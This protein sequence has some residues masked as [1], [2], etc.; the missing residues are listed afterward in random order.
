MKFAKGFVALVILTSLLATTVRAQNSFSA[1]DFAQWENL[2]KG[3]TV[4]DGQGVSPDELDDWGGPDYWGY[5][6]RD[7]NEL[8]GPTYAWVDV[9]GVGEQ[10]TITDTDDGTQLINLLFPFWFYGDYYNQVNISSNGNIHFGASDSDWSNSF[11]PSTDGP[12]AMIAP[13]WDDIAVHYAN[14]GDIY[15]YSTADSFIVQ[16]ENVRRHVLAGTDSTSRYTF[17]VIIYPDSRIKFQY[18]SM[19]GTLNSATIGIENMA[20]TGGLLILYN[21]GYVENNLAIEIY[22]RPLPFTLGTPADGFVSGST[23]LDLTWNPSLNPDPTE[24]LTYN[25]FA[26]TDPTDMGV[27][28]ATGIA[29]TF[30]NFTGLD[31]ATYYWTIL[32]ND[33]ESPGTQADDT[34]SFHITVPEPPSAFNLLTPTDGNTEGSTTPTLTWSASVDP[35]AGDVVTYNIIYSIGDAT[36]ADPDSIT[37]INATSYTFPDGTLQDDITVYWYVRAVDTNT[38]GTLS[39]RNP[40][41]NFAYRFEIYETEAPAAFN[42]SGPA[43]RVTVFD[44]DTTLS[45]QS[46]TEPDP[47]DALTGYMLWVATNEAFTQNLDSVAFTPL[48]TTYTMGGLV[49]NTTYWWKVRA[50]DGNTNGT[51]SDQTLSFHYYEPTSPAA[52]TPSSPANHSNHTTSDV[53][54]EWNSSSDTNPAN[55]L[56]IHGPDTFGYFWLDNNQPGGPNYA[57]VD[58]SGTG[59]PS[60]AA[61]GAE[62]Q[63]VVAIPFNFPFYGVEYADITID[64]NGYLSFGGASDFS[65]SGIPGIDGPQGMIAA[66]WDDLQPEAIGNIYYQSMGTWFVVQYDGVQRFAD[67][68]S[69]ET[70]QIILFDDGRIR[71]QYEDVSGTLNSCTVGIENPDEN[72]GLEVTFN[73]N[74][75]DDGLALEFYPYAVTYE[76]EWATVASFAGSTIEETVDAT[77]YNITGCPDN[78]TMYWRAHATNIYNQSTTIT[79]NTGWDFTTS[80]PDPP[81]GFNLTSPADGFV[82]ATTDII[83]QWEEATDPDIGDVITYEVYITEIDGV[84]G[85][86]VAT[87]LA[88]NQYSFTGSFGTQ[89]WWRIRAIDNGGLGTYSD[90]TWS[91]EIVTPTP[92][93]AFNVSS[94]AI[95][96]EFANLTPTVVWRQTTDNDPGDAVNYNVIWSLNDATF[97][98]PDSVTGLS[99][100]TYTF[101]AGDLADD[102]TV[103]WYVRATD[104]NTNGRNS[105]QNPNNNNTWSFTTN[106]PDVPN[107]FGLVSPANNGTPNTAAVTLQWQAATDPD[108]GDNITYEVYVATTPGGFGGPTAAGLNTTQYVFNGTDNQQYYWKV[109]A[110]DT[111]SAGTWSTET[112]TFTIVEPD[113]PNAFDLTGPANGSTLQTTT[114]TLTWDAATDPDAGDVIT[115][116]LV[117]SVG[118]ATFSDPDSVTG[119]TNATYTFGAGTLSDDITLY[120]YVRA[121]DTNTNGTLSSQNPNNGNTWSFSIAVDEAPSAFNLLTPADGTTSLNTTVSLTWQASSDPDPGDNVTYDVYVSENQATVQN[122]AS[123]VATGLNVTNLDYAGVDNHVYYWQIQAI[124]TDGNS[125]WSSQQWDFSI[126]VPDPPDAFNLTGPLDNATVTSA[127]P[128]LTWETTTDPDIGDNVTYNVIWAVNDPTFADPDSAV[129]LATATYTFSAGIL[130]DDQPVYWYVRAVDTNTNGRL[131][132]QNPND[133]TT[134]HFDMNVPE[135]PAV[136]DLVSPADGVYIEGLT[137]NLEWDATTDPDPGDIINYEVYVS[138]DQATVQNIANRVAQSLSVVTYAFNGAEDQTYYWTIRAVDTGNN[139]TWASTTRSF[140]FGVSETPDAFSLMAPTDGETVTTTTPILSWQTATDPDPGDVVTY[141]VIWSRNDATFS[142]PDSATGIATANYTFS[143]GSINDGDQVYWYVRAVD[144][145]TNGRL[146]TQNPNDGTTWSFD[147]AIAEAPVAFDLTAPANGITLAATT[148]DLEWNASSDPD[149]GDVITYDVYLSTDPGTLMNPGSRIAQGVSNTFYTFNGT[150]DQTYYWRIKAIDSNSPGTWSNQA[151]SF[152]F[153]I[154]EQPTAFNLLTP[155]NMAA[156]NTLTPTLTWQQSTDPDPGDAVSYTL[157]YSI[158]DAS[159]AAPTTIT[160]LTNETWSFPAGILVDEDVVHWY[161]HAV[162]NNTAGTLSTPNPVDGTARQ[163]EITI[164]DAPSSFSLLGPANGSTTTST[165]VVF[166]WQESTDPDAGDVVTYD[167]YVSQDLLTLQDVGNRVAQGLS[168]E[169]YTFNGQDDNSYFWQ[170]KAV[171]TNSPGTW[172]T[173]QWDFSISNP[174]QPTAFDLQTPSDGITVNTTTPTLTWDV[175]TD[176]DAGDNVTY[177]VIWSVDD[178]TFSSPDSV[179]GLTATSYTFSAGNLPDNSTVHWYVRAIDTNTNGRL[180]TRNPRDNTAYSF[181]ILVPEQPSSF[182]LLSPADGSLSPSTSVTLNWEASVDPDPG[183]AVTYEVYISSNQATVTDPASRVAQNVVST[184]YTYNGT[185]NSQYFWTIKA[186]DMNTTGRWATQTWDFSVGVADPPSEFAL[187]GPADG[188]TILDTTEV[189]F[190]WEQATDPDA[191][192][193]VTYRLYYSIGDI[194]FTNPTV[195]SGI[196]DTTYTLAPGILEDGHQ[197]YWYVRAYDTNS[198]TYTASTPAPSNGIPWK[199]DI[200]ITDAPEPF[201]LVSPINNSTTGNHI[202]TLTW[203]DTEDPDG[204]HTPTFDVYLASDTTGGLRIPANRIVNGWSD[205]TYTFI[206]DDDSTYYWT[207]YATDNNTV[208]T[209]ANQAW[210]FTIGEAESPTAFDLISPTNGATMGTT[211]PTLTWRRSTDPDPGD[212]VTYRLYWSVNDPTFASPAFVSGLTD[213][214]YTFPGGVLNDDVTYYWYVLA[215]DGNTA[216]TPSNQSPQNGNPYRFDVYVNDTPAAFSLLSPVNNYISP[217]T[218]VTLTW[219]ASSESDPG[220]NLTY[221]VYLSTNLADLGQPFTRVA[222]GLTNTTHT[223]TLTDD[224]TYYWQVKA[225]DTN[226]AGTISNETWQFSIGVPDAPSA[227]A[228]VSPAAGVVLT[229]TTPTLT[230]ER[231]TDPDPGDALTYTVYW[232][233]S[234]PSFTTPAFTAGLTDTSYTFPAGI[235]NDHETVYWYVK[236][237]DTN[238]A[239]TRSTP[240]PID[241]TARSFEIYIIDSPSAFNL[242][243]PDQADTVTSLDAQLSWEESVDPDV[244]DIVTYNVYVSFDLG[245]LGNPA[246]LIASGLDTTGY[247]FHGVED[248]LYYWTVKAVDTNSPGTWADEVRSFRIAIPERP[249]PFNLGSPA[250]NIILQTMTPTLTWHP[251]TDADPGDVVTYTVLYT[252]GDPLFIS[253]VEITG[254][255]DTSYTFAAGMLSD[256]NTV[257]WYVKAV[258]LNSEGRRS[259]QN[260]IDNTA[261]RF[262]LVVP[263]PPAAFTLLSPS[264]GTVATT[265]NVTLTW[266]STTDPDP[267]DVVTY[268]LYVSTLRN[269]LG[270]PVISGYAGTSYVYSGDDDST[271]YWAVVATDGNTAGTWS[272][273]TLSFSYSI[274]DQPAAFQLLTPSNNGVVADTLPTLTWQ[275]AIDPDPGD[276]VTYTLQYDFNADFST[277]TEVAGL[278]TTSYTLPTPLYD[279]AT[280]FWRVRAVD[281]NTAGTWAGPP[282]YFQFDVFVQDVPNPFN[283]VS[284]ANNGLSNP[285]GSVTLVWENNGDPDLGHEVVY[286]VYV[287]SQPDM[288]DAVSFGPYP[289]GTF[290]TLNQFWMQDDSTYYWRVWAQDEV[291]AD[292]RWSNEI[293]A[294]TMHEPELPYAFDLLTPANGD[295]SFDGSPTFTWENNGDPDPNQL[296]TYTLHLGQDAAFNNR[297]VYGPYDEDVF[298]TISEPWMVDGGRYWWKVY[299]H[300]AEGDSVQSAQTWSF[301]IYIPEPPSAFNRVY[302]P[303]DGQVEDLDPTL[304]WQRATD[305][306]PGDQITYTLEWSFNSDFSNLT[307]VTG[308]ADTFYTYPVGQLFDDARVY[309]RVRAV[310]RNSGTG[311]W[312]GPTASWSFTVY[313]HEQP[314]AFSLLTPADG[315][316]LDPS[317]SVIL[318]WENN[319][320]PDPNQGVSYELQVAENS[321]FT[322]SALYGPFNEGEFPTL[323]QLVLDDDTQYW[324]R[325]VAT[326][327]WTGGHVWSTET[328]T[329]FI[330]SPEVPLPFDLVSPDSGVTVPNLGPTLIWEATTD[331]DPGESVTYTLQYAFNAGF[332]PSTSIADLTDPVYTFTEAELLNSME[333]ML[334]DEELDE[335]LPDDVTVYWRVRA[336]DDSGRS[337]LSGPSAYWTFYVFV[338]DPPNAFSLISPANDD[339]NT[340]GSVTFRWENQ[341]DPDPGQNVTYTLHL[342]ENPWFSSPDVYGPYT[343]NDFPTFTPPILE[344]DMRYWWKVYAHDEVSGDSIVSNQAWSFWV[345]IPEPPGAFDR[346]SP[347]HL[348]EVNTLG[349]TLMWE[350]APE[351][352]SS[353]SVSYTMEWAFLPDF[354]GSDSVTSLVDTFYTFENTTLMNAYREQFG[355]DDNDLD[356]LLPDNVTVFWRVRAVDTNT[357]G[358]WAGPTPFW[359]FDIYW[360]QMPYPFAL[361]SPVLGDT[362]FDGSVTFEWENNGDPDPGQSVIYSIHVCDDITFDSDI[363]YLGTYAEGETPTVTPAWLEDDKQ[364]WWR[365]FA[366]DEVLGDSLASTDTSTFRTYFPELPAAFDLVSPEDSSTVNTLGP[367]LVWHASSDPDPDDTLTYRV[368]WGLTPQLPGS[369]VITGITDTTYTFTEEEISA[370]IREEYGS[371][372]EGELDELLPDDVTIYWRVHATDR[373]TAGTLSGPAEYWQFDV[374]VSESP[375]AFSLLS[376]LDM[377]TVWVDTVQLTWEASFDPDPDNE[378]AYDLL[379]KTDLDTAFAVIAT[380]LTDTTCILDS[381]QD[382]RIYQWTVYAQDSNTPGI[383]ANDTL[384]FSTY[385]PEPPADFSLLQP[386]D[387]VEIHTSVVNLR[388]EE[389]PDPDP[390]N[391]VTYD[392]Y[393]EIDGGH[394]GLIAS[395]LDTNSF[396]WTLPADDAEITWRVYARDTNTQ[397]TWSSNTFTMFINKHEPPLPFSLLSPDSSERLETHSPTVVWES[398]IDPDPYDWVTYTLVWSVNDP[399]FLLP[400]S[401]ANLDDTTFTFTSTMLNTGNNGSQSNT[402]ITDLDQV[403]FRAGNTAGSGKKQY[404]GLASTGSSTRSQT[405]STSLSGFGSST[406]QQTGSLTNELDSFVDDVTVYWYVRAVDQNS[407]GRLSNQN[408]VDNTLINFVID[409]PEPPEPFN[410]L[411]PSHNREIN[412]ESVVFRW[413]QT[414]DPDPNDPVTYEIY[415]SEDPDSMGNP[416]ASGLRS[417]NYTWFGGEDDVRY[418]W[419]VRAVDSNSEGRM[420]SQTWRFFMRLPNPPLTFNLAAP[421][422]GA[423]LYELTPTITWFATT[424][425]DPGDDITYTLYFADNPDFYDADSIYALS[426]TSVTIPDDFPFFERLLENNDGGQL[427]GVSPVEEIVSLQPRK[428]SAK[429]SSAK[430]KQQPSL[431][432]VA[433][434]QETGTVKVAS[435][436]GELNEG[437]ASATVYWR[438]KAYDSNSD[439]TWCTPEEGWTFDLFILQPPEPFD[440]ISPP[441]GM[442]STTDEITFEWGAGHDES[443]ADSIT[444]ILEL[445]TSS[446][447]VN[448]QRYTVGSA[449]S[450]T[451]TDLDDD[452]SYWWRVKARD[453]INR[454]SRSNQVWTVATSFPNPPTSFALLEPADSAI[455]P[456]TIPHE[457]RFAWQQSVDPDPEEAELLR[458]SITLDLYL[459]GAIDTSVTFREL[460]EHAQ[461]IDIVD[462]LGLTSWTGHLEINWYV[463]AISGGD[464]VRSFNGWT[465][466]L[467][468]PQ[469]ES[470]WGDNEIPTEYTV[471]ATYPNPFNARLMIVVALPNAGRVSFDIYNTLGQK[472]TSIPEREYRQGYHQISWE[473]TN[474]AAGM[475]FLR[476]NAPHGGGKVRRI[477][478]AP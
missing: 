39:T 451:V 187:I 267:G 18:A 217:S 465:V 67:A 102:A 191:G 260:P 411:L 220:D 1:S 47:D 296:V 213:T 22:G 106:V 115:Y 107:P 86:P 460:E 245:T 164:V 129:G 29:D 396:D 353:D 266:E 388:W 221:S 183:D 456:W 366:H 473:A 236:A 346:L 194:N 23:T 84:W 62:Q 226:T 180:S 278:T 291:L 331:P 297:S 79:P 208:G 274:P 431:S 438:V 445:S 254:L 443:N 72:D 299:A 364:Y 405:Y 227:F 172:S 390:D 145:N 97:S 384:T 235:L 229:T 76:V 141:N 470:P 248:T 45:W 453:T 73:A 462:S 225:V 327:E 440:L 333:E 58:I 386:A 415:I 454:E 381:L 99:D 116:N 3:S 361:I 408:P 11:I 28:V 284:P 316:I 311:T 34:L 261:Y 379:V 234:D 382:D 143:S 201:N 258:D 170:V 24:N 162:D 179:T 343:E 155:I 90:Q 285:D 215:M 422:S 132:T 30:Y 31:D 256:N 423:L 292:G 192:D 424:D 475:Y 249:T 269:N 406:V 450:Y 337:R 15:Y 178:A 188:S 176:P 339:T 64:N 439:G 118:D 43:D 169:T 19:T 419:T 53:T 150:E 105:N 17:E 199:F 410:L 184:S 469:Q 190:V 83:L 352:D 98:N 124:D 476:M 82:S 420:A 128:T 16:W 7:S 218:S 120:W 149:P 69:I 471:A 103:Y 429:Q 276:V 332:V 362:S 26:S 314:Y 435:V 74:Y 325:V 94:P 302:P 166:T 313:V 334:G 387:S 371:D 196:S 52:F 241:G 202:V 46:T 109:R 328:W 243:T 207:V 354:T 367:T 85:A 80:Q 341:N 348:A 298:P 407:N 304:T 231:S 96:T 228:L 380:G 232:S 13:W 268:S 403:S 50:L 409:I 338:Q 477:I 349:P 312:A 466:F 321:N 345:Y 161:V 452:V 55:G 114:P 104:S 163:F 195:I 242:L 158:N 416:V 151:W 66:F 212:N 417:T 478:Y 264:D 112:W 306:D 68:A 27:A 458:Y 326:D 392:V 146:S 467:D 110:V 259:N 287:A 157:Y 142:S 449:L 48:Q 6:W 246:T 273:D 230:W 54:V 223:L 281:T 240:N 329:F 279:G 323:D 457:M 317:P 210:R 318:E 197:V 186:V 350:S 89:Y 134:W 425:P 2:P 441:F 375:S 265:Q 42:L 174:E 472:V 455:V 100:T 233:I 376:P 330:Y 251:S 426:D 219:E 224:L 5:R 395:E 101:T 117:Y 214:V 95:G 175:S 88:V 368:I 61:V 185:D 444:Y 474:L 335:L 222:Q 272:D 239:G 402:G 111:N 4:A 119:L 130:A 198:G 209:W 294:F 319:G 200:Y 122:L 378:V 434:V 137:A 418:Y 320:D 293:W 203:R 372:G 414:E 400:D 391:Q 247:T 9:S 282:S 125:T 32:A 389:A 152:T 70:F 275:D 446:S 280:V 165:S 356:E 255:A 432:Q 38:N 399:T 463:D 373:N 404:T 244:G 136:F 448:A 153:S 182:A 401:I 93:A 56:A 87:N 315:S 133:G 167:V 121:V 322:G 60:T 160:G 290:P 75:L 168:A 461:L 44:A 430:K 307:T 428:Q 351:Y 377:D 468:G 374:Y 78:Q 181:N 173:E 412:T 459:Q 421:D 159:F 300:D 363:Q 156:M 126:G 309:W 357:N 347:A 77:D 398:T 358:T 286:T 365:V 271:Y 189:N 8:N 283:L 148:V 177:R 57:W 355:G 344:D 127:T 308:L 250:N 138:T 342:S 171:D 65:N 464:T 433:L 205:T 135:P 370:V 33:S 49:S 301:R 262:H 139:G 383:W 427:L 92:P 305:P 144:T 253:P 147:V 263:E 397:G 436:S 140:T 447:F 193:V 237:V 41:D 295:T 123:R 108:P 59:T 385:F 51:W 20:Q 303:D 40:R 36:F 310:D 442:V 81:N 21:D 35:D 288:S 25:V 277:A 324:W 204:N 252:I 340:T 216:G 360:Q 270:T 91:Y 238:S 257:Y 37:G 71:Y 369:N 131:S 206:G 359:A 12:A 113:P 394:G 154:P 211:S 14:G 393:M 289:E 63:E 336:I 413:E 10:A 437:D